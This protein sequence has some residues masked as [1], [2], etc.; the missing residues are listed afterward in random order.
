MG[1]CVCVHDGVYD[2]RLFRTN[3]GQVLRTRVSAARMR[4]YYIILYDAC[5]VNLLGGYE[6]NH[7]S[8]NTY[9]IECAEKCQGFSAVGWRDKGEKIV[10]FNSS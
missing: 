7:H 5:G 1:L 4:L 9:A 6:L 10:T 2:A 8:A 3:V